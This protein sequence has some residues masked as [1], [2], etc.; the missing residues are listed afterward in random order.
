MTIIKKCDCKHDFQD[1][2]YGKQNRVHN[3][4]TNKA[5]CTVCSKEKPN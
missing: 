4:G 2:E 5:T 3:K 1:K